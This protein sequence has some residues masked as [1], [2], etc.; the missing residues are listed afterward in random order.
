MNKLRSGR[1]YLT[2]MDILGEQ[3]QSFNI[4]YLDF[5]LLIG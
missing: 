5:F 1:P 3:A 4:S 2:V